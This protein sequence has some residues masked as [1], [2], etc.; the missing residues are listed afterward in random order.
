MTASRYWQRQSK[1]HQKF[2]KSVSTVAAAFRNLAPV[3]VAAALR[4]SGIRVCQPIERFDVS[5]PQH[6][7]VTVMA[8][9]GRLGAV[10]HDTAVAGRYLET[11]SADPSRATGTRGSVPYR[12][13]P[14]HS[15]IGNISGRRGGNPGTSTGGWKRAGNALAIHLPGRR[16]H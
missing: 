5:L 3:V 13:R 1:P 11:S 8:L 9:L 16:P 14:L 15:G 6:A 12:G 4:Q 7:V 2:D 10:V